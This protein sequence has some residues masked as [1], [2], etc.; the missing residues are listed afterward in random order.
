MSAYYDYIYDGFDDEYVQ[1]EEELRDEVEMFL[2]NLSVE[3][4]GHAV[5]WLALEDSNVEKQLHQFIGTMF[6]GLK[7]MPH[8]LSKMREWMVDLM[9]KDS[10]IYLELREFFK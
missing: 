6:L 10:Q 3:Q 8:E 5:A 1:T 4:F 2:D 9:H 7:P